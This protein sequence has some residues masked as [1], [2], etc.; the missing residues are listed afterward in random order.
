MTKRGEFQQIAE[1]FAPLA[2][3]FPGALGL[4]DDAALVSVPEGQELVVTMDAIVEGIHYLPDDPPDL[5]ARKLI[6]VNLSDLAAKGATPLALMLACAF[7]RRLDDRWREGFAR[8]L[9]QDVAA[10]SVPVIGGDTVSTSGPAT[11]SLTAFG[12]VAK[13]QAL[14]RSGARTGD[15]L[16]VSGTLGDGAFGLLAA[17]GAL[18]G[19]DAEATA[20]LA[21]RYRVPQ[22]RV[23]VGPRCLGLASAAMDISDGLLQDLG[24]LCAASGVRGL[25]EADRLPLSAAVTAL[26]AQRPDWLTTVATG[27]DDYE[28]LMAVPPESL[29]QLSRNAIAEGVK[30]SVIGRCVAGQGVQLL[31]SEGGVVDI[32]RAGFSHF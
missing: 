25:V 26:T 7:P 1:L 28:L 10:F 22:P 4:K 15:L 12:L 16:V 11:F 31:D 5:V 20:W 18:T 13:G 3:G 9:A 23:T 2:A 24:H 27:G 29:D 19:L 6:R 30:V 17:Q 14:L 21:D 8:G 32:G